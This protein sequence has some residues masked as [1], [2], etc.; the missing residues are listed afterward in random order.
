MHT[1]LFIVGVLF[2]TLSAIGVLTG[3]L[4]AVIR[5]GPYFGKPAYNIARRVGTHCG[6]A[7]VLL[8][9]FSVPF[10]VFTAIGLWVQT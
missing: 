1:M 8:F 7:W 10:A 9:C 2:L 6:A 5:R 3:T 4:D